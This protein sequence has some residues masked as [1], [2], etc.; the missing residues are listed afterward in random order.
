MKTK[1]AVRYRRHKGGTPYV[2]PISLEAD[3]HNY[4]IDESPYKVYSIIYDDNTEE[5]Q[6][7]LPPPEPESIEAIEPPDLTEAKPIEIESIPIIKKILLKRK[8][9]EVTKK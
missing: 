5:V 9:S 1:E 6:M 8:K 2:I 4:K 7:K 3:I